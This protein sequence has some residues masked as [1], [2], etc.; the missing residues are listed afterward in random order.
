VFDLR[1]FGLA[2]V[3]ECSAVLRRLGG[4]ATSLEGAARAVVRYLFDS[5]IDKEVD[6]PALALV[7]LYK[8]HRFDQLE[9]DL[10]DFAA[11][12]SPAGAVQ[13]DAP[14]LTLLGTAGEAPAW[15][16]RRQSEGHRAIPVD[17]PSAV[18]AMPMV[19]QLVR[20]LGIE[21]GELTQPHPKWFEASRGRS[22]GVFYVPDAAA[23]AYVP[24]K[25]FV[26]RHGIVSVVGFGDLLPSGYAFAVVMFAKV[27]VTREVADMFAPL[28]FATQ[29]ALLPFVERRL[30]DS[31]PPAAT[32]DPQRDLRIARAEA[33][34]LDRLLDA[35]QDIVTDQAARLEQARRE[36]EDRADALGRSQRLLEES[37]A[38]KAAI[39]NAALD[40]VITMDEAGT[41]VDFNPAAEALFGYRRE[42]ATGRV[43]AD[44]IV[45]EELREAHRGGVARF[46]RTGR[47]EIIGRRVEMTAMRSDG[48]RFPIELTVAAVNAGGRQLFSGHVRDITDRLATERV[49]R[50]A[51]ERY[52][53]IARTLQ[54]SLLPPALP[55]IAGAEVAAIYR[56]G[57]DGLEVGGDFYDLFDLGD[58]RWVVVLGDVM[59][60]GPRAAATTALARYTIRA[61]AMRSGEP[62]EV[63]RVLNEALH[64]DDPERFCTAAVC[65]IETGLPGRLS[66]CSGGHLPPLLRRG[67]EVKMLEASGTLLGPFPEWQGSM[68][69]TELVRGDLLLLYSDGLVEAR[70]GQ[71]Q[72]GLGRLVEAVAATVGLG[73]D[74]TVQAVAEAAWQFST[75]SSDD[76]AILAY[77]VSSA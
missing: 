18:A 5:L 62:A 45:P 23:S 13:A 21:E 34:A 50:E 72:F 35:R 70:R 3:L 25:D 44:L 60:K 8:T 69:T 6:A 53:E 75:G 58:G 22:G 65:V 14:C 52:A 42:E 51:S 2:D 29:V 49:L 74:P 27:E 63:L 17:D 68:V 37:E 31:D 33:A 24:D 11:R 40:A 20:Q 43:L 54:A 19:A 48:T 7:R 39:L 73:P 28:S 10:Q 55:H 30:F 38:V 4:G 61:A 9:P 57:F 59:G 26:E 56:S 46:L 32:D 77:Q 47:A 36:A 66:V 76:V 12:V 64:R 1:S 15:N 41:V 16:D 67:Q 71:E